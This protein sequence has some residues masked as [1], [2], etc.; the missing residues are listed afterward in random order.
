MQQIDTTGA[1]GE[2]ANAPSLEKEAFRQKVTEYMSKA[3]FRKEIKSMLNKGTQRLN[4][5]IDDLRRQ[6]QALAKYVTKNP[7]DAVSMFEGELD[8][9]IKEML[10]DSGK[11]AN[12]EKTAANVNDKAFPTKTKRYYIN[13]DGNFGRNHVTPRG[14]KAQLVN[15]LVSVR[16]IVTR[17]GLV[18]PMI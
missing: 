2:Q 4:V 11:G 9:T 13:F 12:N 17:M 3:A 14:L 5:P 18:K 15:Q 10:D 6:D 1:A 7:I 16:G 8:R